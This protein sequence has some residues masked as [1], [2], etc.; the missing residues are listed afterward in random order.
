MKT[1]NLLIRGIPDHVWTAIKKMA[2]EEG[3]SLNQMY[4]KLIYK[5]LHRFEKEEA[6]KKR[7][8]ESLR[9]LEKLREKI[10]KKYGVCNEDFSGP[11]NF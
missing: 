1:T 6:E 3:L 10:H 7:R 4:L 5:M 2:E 9:R 11:E 8:R